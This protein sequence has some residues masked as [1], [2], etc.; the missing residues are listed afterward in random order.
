MLHITPG[1]VEHAKER[2]QELRDRAYDY[3]IKH[4]KKN[5]QS[6]TKMEQ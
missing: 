4:N 6:I 3:F 1:N 5:K 2:I